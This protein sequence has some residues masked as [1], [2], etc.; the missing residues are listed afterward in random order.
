[1]NAIDIVEID[2][3]ER[4]EL[5]RKHISSTIRTRLMLTALEIKWHCDFIL[6]REN[7]VSMRDLKLLNQI[8][9]HMLKATNVEYL[10]AIKFHKIIIGAK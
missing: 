6:R 10:S 8:A 9:S 2:E 5:F 4:W 7:A 3:E 1:V